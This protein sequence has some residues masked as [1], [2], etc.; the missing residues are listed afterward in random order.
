MPVFTKQNLPIILAFALPIALI[1]VVSLVIYIPKNSVSTDYNFLYATCDDSSRYYY[2]YNCKSL[3]QKKYTVTNNK[4]VVNTV[5][6][7][8]DYNGDGILD[9]VDT[10]QTRLFLH[11]SKKNESKEITLQESQ[12]YNLHSLLTSPDSVTISYDYEGSYDVFPFYNGRSSSGYYLT[13]GD[14]K[15]KLNLIESGR[16]YNE[17]EFYFIG[18]ILN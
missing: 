18:W 17:N 1:I 12:S 5:A 9:E 7:F 11:D 13:K 14:G 3:L 8:K 2:S 10:Y 15:S 16:Y 6:P 4:L